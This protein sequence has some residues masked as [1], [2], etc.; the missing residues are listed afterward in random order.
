MTRG[1]YWDLLE[2]KIDEEEE[3]EMKQK[4]GLQGASASISS[5]SRVFASATFPGP[6][7]GRC[8]I[9]GVVSCRFIEEFKRFLN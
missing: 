7:V 5:P 2:K 6:Y 3:P 8:L 4:G 1:V 9:P